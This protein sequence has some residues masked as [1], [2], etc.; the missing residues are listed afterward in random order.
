[1]PFADREARNQYM[2]EYRER[3]REPRPPAPQF[4]HPVNARPAVPP[5]GRDN[6]RPESPTRQPAA[7]FT[8]PA[9]PP[10]TRPFMPPRMIGPGA[11]NWDT[12]FKMAVA[13]A[14]CGQRQVEVCGGQQFEVKIL[15][16]AW[17]VAAV[18]VLGG[19]VVWWLLSKLSNPGVPG[20]LLGEKP[21][22]WVH[23]NTGVTL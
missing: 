20:G 1:M 8:A 9:S 21:R 22:E 18:L 5:A 17:K 4:S 19:F 16:S 13:R 6:V 10:T 2:R 3:Q 23:W 14:S 11:A 12:G 15:P 7:T